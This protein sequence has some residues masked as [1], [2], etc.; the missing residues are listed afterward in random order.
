VVSGGQ[1]KG[2]PSATSAAGLLFGF[3]D[4]DVSKLS[5]QEFNEVWAA[6]GKVARARARKAPSPPEGTV[7][8]E[9]KPD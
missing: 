4:D 1:S 7:D 5:D 8:E 6:L 3:T 2:T 9:V